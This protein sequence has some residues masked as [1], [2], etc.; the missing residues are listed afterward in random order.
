M[1]QMTSLQSLIP[2]R[3]I[4][5]N[6]DRT[7]NDQQYIDTFSEPYQSRYLSW[8]LRQYYKFCFA[9]MPS[10]G[11]V[12]ILDLGCGWA[13]LAHAI[14]TLSARHQS[15]SSLSLGYTGVDIK[16]ENIDFL[17]HAY[18]GMPEF[19]FYL[20]ATQEQVDYIGEYRH[21]NGINDA[22][23]SSQSSGVE[24][25]YSFL[26][27]DSYDIQWSNS[28][29][30]HLTPSAVDL[31]LNSI[32]RCLKPGGISINCL[33]LLDPT[34]V[35]AM[36]LGLADRDLRLD[37]GSYFTYSRDNPLLC[38]GYKPEFLLQR[39]TAH[40]LNILDIQYGHWR[41]DGSSNDIDNYIDIIV[42]QKSS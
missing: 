30:T 42:A 41:G 14:A 32:A 22:R 27:R 3:R 1:L 19:K 9:K 36:A 7:L 6:H 18:A 4:N 28:L 24:S 8:I 11:S 25:D 16:A 15:Y 38:T 20:Q 23:T 26:H 21:D 35:N 39:Y 12:S 2:P 13:P 29:I 17:S 5:S 31:C 34:A 33:L 40:G 37:M 10:N